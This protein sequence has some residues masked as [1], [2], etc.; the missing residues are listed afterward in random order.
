MFHTDHDRGQRDVITAGKE[1]ILGFSVASRSYRAGDGGVS[2]KT[3]LLEDP[4]RRGIACP[5]GS[6]KKNR[7]TFIRDDGA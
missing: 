4:A 7:L 5:A 2:M 1:A 6:H 3:M